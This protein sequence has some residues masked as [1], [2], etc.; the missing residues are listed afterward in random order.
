MFRHISERKLSSAKIKAYKLFYPGADAAAM[1]INLKKDLSTLDIMPENIY[2]MTGTNNVDPIYYGKSSLKNAMRD[3]KELIDFVKHSYPKSIVHVIN[4]LPRDTLG[5]NEIVDELN[6]MIEEYCLSSVKGVNFMNSQ[7]LFKYHNG[8]R[9]NRY[10]M[11][12]NQYYNDNCHL[13]REGVKRLGKYLKYWAH[14]H[15][16]DENS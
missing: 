2:L 6:I 14:Q 5:R 11:H 7:K 12:P 13:N 10:F 16:E 1:L 15:L 4:I 3:I 8:S 9:S